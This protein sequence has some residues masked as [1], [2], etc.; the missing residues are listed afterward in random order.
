MVR[1]SR[2][3][4]VATIL[5][6]VSL[7]AACGG[8]E[9]ANGDGLVTGGP[10]VRFDSVDQVVGAFV[11][12][13]A[14]NGAS[15]TIVDRDEGIIHETFSGEMT[16][17]RVVLLAS[18]SKMISAGV[19][20]ALDDRGLLDLDAPI[21]E[22]VPWGEGNPSVTPAQLVSN[23][24]GLPSSWAYAPYR[25]QW[26]P[27][28][29]L[30]ACGAEIMST[31]ADDGDVVPPDTRFDYGGAQW[32][33]AGAVAEAVTGQTWSD[34]VDEIFV[35][36]CGLTSLGYNNHF[37]YLP[38][39]SGDS[40]PPTFN[41]DI[42]KFIATENPNIE[43]G[44]YS[45][46]RDY[47]RLLHMLLLGGRCGDERVLSESAVA[48]ALSDRIDEAYGGSAKAGTGYGL[49]WWIDRESGRRSD[50]G[51]YGSYPY[52]DIEDGYAVLILV[53]KQNWVGAALADALF[54]VIDE[55]MRNFRA[56]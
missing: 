20:L 25:C 8:T 16:P 28:A 9:T 21:A 4:V 15:V 54:D 51:L 41:G 52:I 31:T 44:A 48:S 22:V 5:A 2:A 23:S 6:L 49:G 30:E 34:L 40:Y 1:S 53:E 33:V 55:E 46:S 32:Q 12:S 39:G 18:S 43:G 11:Q 3:P 45:T 56:T 38:P 13:Q 24:S 35:E 17:E 50:G 37:A 29:E 27:S 19:V 42:S 47:A 14:L 26:S 10:G 7:A 36:P